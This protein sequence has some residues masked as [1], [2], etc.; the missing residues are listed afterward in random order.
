MKT[1]GV[2]H[3][4][5]QT[6]RLLLLLGTVGVWLLGGAQRDARAQF[7]GLVSENEFELSEIVQLD[8]ADDTVLA[9][10]MQRVKDYLGV[11]QWG[12]AVETLRRMIENSHGKLF[13]IS[14]RRYVRLRD[15]CH[16]QLASM[17]DEALRLYRSQVDATA[18]QWYAQGIEQRDRRLLGNVVE[19]A[20]ASSWGDDALLAL[21]EMALESGDYTAARWH[22]ERII[23][24]S[25][26]PATW[27]GYPDTDL[28][29]PSVLARLVLVSILEGSTARARGELAALARNCPDARGRLGGREVN[30]VEALGALLAESAAWPAEKRSAD[31]PTF[32]GSA[33]RNTIAP[34]M[35]EVAEVAWRV[36]LR[37]SESPFALPLSFHPLSVGPLVPVNTQ[38][39]ILVLEAAT[40]K[41]AWKQTA[42]YRAAFEGIAG[43]PFHPPNVLGI[44]QC[45]MTAHHGK[46][47]ARMGTAVT[48]RP[49]E[50]EQDFRPG[51]LVGIDLATEGG[52]IWWPPLTPEPGWAFE[53]SPVAD[54][55][56]IYVAMRRSDVR[57]QAHVACFDA[58]TGRRRW[59]T[60]ICSAET[61]AG[62]IFYE[63]THNL[64]T[65]EGE[66]IYYN[67]NLGAVA[68]LAAADGRL[69]W[70][71]LYPRET[72]G[73]LS[74][75]APHWRRDLN[76]C[77][78]DRGTL[79]V[80]PADCPE[81][82]ALDA[83]TGGELWRTGSQV[84]DVL[85]L[86]GTT[87]EHLIAG[88]EKLYWIA[89]SGADRGR[90]AHYWPDGNEK[91]GYGRG[92]LAGD[93]VLWPTR[94][95]IYVFDQKTARLK[96]AIDLVP[97]GVT[98]GN[99]LVADGRLLIATAT[100]LIALGRHGSRPDM[101]SQELP[102][103]AL[104]GRP[105]SSHL[106]PQDVAESSHLAPQDVAESSHLAP[107]DVAESSH[108]A[109]QDV[110]SSR[111]ARRLLS[112][113]KTD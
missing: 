11:G 97:L 93:C 28:D 80:A 36:P 27:P 42:A 107:Q 45:T 90:V 35:I 66:T 2:S 30:Y 59:R 22:W 50:E 72:R 84:E 69:K 81:I 43:A 47:Y 111:G 102:L 87:E 32:A 103:L 18:G 60:L 51:Y 9:Q 76:P 94:Q 13:R 8:Q 64:L 49:Q 63:T 67:T 12:E 99:L 61:P 92:V 38:R 21:G 26:A 98:G 14:D 56:N 41:P 55:A 17:P 52:V 5:S 73:R 96:R 24:H 85:H 3:G 44:A 15:Y 101:N 68:A 23:P 4:V 20:F 88:G 31:W 79:L 34:E 19:Q 74:E 46:L 65:L 112:R 70:I 108:L 91:L 1:G 62:G 25:D 105:R 100:E 16:L 77:L 109:P 82:F 113:T 53:G 54:E 89:L 37:Q 39:E 40:G 57:P 48:S 75:L 95:K 78:Y 58:R 83:V 106:A 33:A 10:D 71:N 86:L 7:G 110:A 104:L 6:P 29:V